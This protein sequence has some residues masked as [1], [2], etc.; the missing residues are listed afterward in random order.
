MVQSPEKTKRCQIRFSS[1]W[2]VQGQC[3][4][5]QAIII[6]ILSGEPRPNPRMIP[7]PHGGP[8]GLCNVLGR[9]DWGG[10]FGVGWPVSSAS[11]NN[12]PRFLLQ[13]FFSE[14]ASQ[15]QRSF[16]KNVRVDQGIARVGG[17][18]IRIV[19]YLPTTLLTCLP[20]RLPYRLVLYLSE[21]VLNTTM[22]RTGAFMLL[23]YLILIC[24]FVAKPFHPFHPYESVTRKF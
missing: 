16:S 1:Y 18:E 2:A 12:K 21:S 4:I 13:G 15:R 19:A 8:H 10:S 6:T 7:R 17:K 14:A 23:F 9:G 20:S 3:G 5:K 24:P 22:E 11:K